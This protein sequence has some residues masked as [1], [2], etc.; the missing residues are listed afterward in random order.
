MA[1]LRSRQKNMTNAIFQFAAGMPEFDLIDIVNEEA[2]SN[3]L[4]ER[5]FITDEG[6]FVYR[7]MLIVNDRQAEK[8]GLEG[9]RFEFYTVNPQKRLTNAQ[10][11]IDGF[12]VIFE[13]SDVETK[14]VIRQDKSQK[15][16]VRTFKDSTMRVFSAAKRGPRGLS[17]QSVPSTTIERTPPLRTI[18]MTAKVNNR[19]P[20]AMSAIGNFATQ[21]LESAASLDSR[22]LNVKKPVKLSTSANTMIKKQSLRSIR[23]TQ[24]QER[25]GG[26]N[27]VLVRTKD[28]DD[29][30]NTGADTTV[31]NLISTKRSITKDFFIDKKKLGNI[32]NLYVI[33]SAIK[34]MGKNNSN[35]DVQFPAV[36]KKIKHAESLFDFLANPEPPEVKIL[37]SRLARVTFEIKKI[38][39]TLSQVAV[40]RIIRNPNAL[41]PTTESRGSISFGANSTQIFTDSLQNVEPNRVTYRFASVNGD[42]SI[43]EFTSIFVPSYQKIT[44]V[45]NPP[46]TPIS[47]LARN[48]G[49]DSVNIEVRTLTED[50]LSFRLLRQEISKTGDFSDSIIQVRESQATKET[51]VLNQKAAYNFIDKNTVLGRKYRYFVAYRLGIP[52][53]AGIS[54]EQLSAEDE[55][56]IRRFSYEPVPF[57]LNIGGAEQTTGADGSPSIN[58]SVDITETTELFNTVLSAL[59]AAGI[60]EEF[61]STLQQDKFKARNFIVMIVERYNTRTGKKVSFGINPVGNFSDNNVTRRN[62]SIPPPLPD[63]DYK[64]I[65]KACLQ[66]PSIF[67]QSANVALQNQFGTEIQ[68]KSSRFT[69]KIWSRL[70]VLP[71]EVDVLNGVSIEKLILESQLGIEIVRGITGLPSNFSFRA[72]NLLQKSYATQLNWSLNGNISFVSHFNIYCTVNGTKNLLGAIAAFSSAESYKFSD[73]RYFDAVGKKSYQIQAVDFDG[74]ELI[75][76]KPIETSKNFSVPEN[77][78][79]GMIYGNFSGIDVI[80]SLL[81]AASTGNTTLPTAPQDGQVKTNFDP[82]S[83]TNSLALQGSSNR[84]ISPQD[85]EAITENLT[86]NDPTSYWAAADLPSFG[87]EFDSGNPTTQSTWKGLSYPAQKNKDAVSIATNLP[88]KDPTSAREKLNFAANDVK[89]K[90][91]SGRVKI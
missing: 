4:E 61:I 55:V 18:N 23:K 11:R 33:I 31:F 59:R 24:R 12:D 88:F 56:L 1:I 19:D 20:A 52:G 48:N 6:Y 7:S 90:I 84:M 41:I 30:Y 50:V 45:Q 36:I 69:R 57:A 80:N 67:L 53:M 63:V 14:T 15:T 62:L 2:K 43:G 29:R 78:M 17:R 85:F 32:N 81:P 89:Q 47:I 71:S 83:I 68:K 87:K 34:K 27:N 38:D 82:N 72:F 26:Q 86:V 79:T 73:D 75:T 39:P 91:A 70:G 65:F 10:N 51:L 40:Y 22:S 58:F 60:G 77:M 64:Y 46:S 54:E 37:D 8:L 21:T 28:S 74:N 13:K 44:D 3:S 42:G 66:D 35:R 5:N 9:M 76:S 49:P 16:D 25:R